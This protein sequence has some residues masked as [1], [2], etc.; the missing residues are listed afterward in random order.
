MDENFALRRS[1]YGDEVIGKDNL[2][3]ISIAQKHNSAAKFSGSGG[4]IVGLCRE[5]AKFSSVREELQAAG[6]VCVPLFANKAPPM[7]KATMSMSA[8]VPMVSDEGSK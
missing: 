5:P 6:F 4:A 1:L 3:M 2:Q 7:K 8:F